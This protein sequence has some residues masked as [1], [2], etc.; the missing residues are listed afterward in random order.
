MREVLS[1]H[2]GQAGVQMG[3]AIWELY[4][5]EHAIGM[6]GYQLQQPAEQECQS[7]FFHMS[8][9][10][11]CIPRSIFIDLEASVVGGNFAVSSLVGVQLEQNR[12]PLCLRTSGSRYCHC[13]WN[14]VIMTGG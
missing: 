8:P 14:I 1:I 3:S 13:Q 12:R 5:A 7:T 9:K 2:V 6:D 10:G 11:Q 4:C